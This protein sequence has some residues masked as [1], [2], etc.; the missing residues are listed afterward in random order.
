MATKTELEK[1][2]DA[3][4]AAQRDHLTADVN[5]FEAGEFAE[6]WLDG[7]HD[8]LADKWMPAGGTDHRQEV[9]N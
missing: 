4:Q 8:E 3:G 6:A 9:S 2:Y 1:A 5:P 7:Y